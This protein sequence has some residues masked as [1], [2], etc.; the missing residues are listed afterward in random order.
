M[1]P[2]DCTDL[3]FR[4]AR[5]Y[6]LESRPRRHSDGVRGAS[7]AHCYLC[8][9][10]LQ[11][12]QHS[13]GAASPQGRPGSAAVRRESER[14]REDVARRKQPRALD[15]VK[16]GGQRQQDEDIVNHQLSAGGPSPW[17]ARGD[18][19]SSRPAARGRGDN[20]AR[21][22]DG[23]HAE[24]VVQEASTLAEQGHRGPHGASGRRALVRCS[25]TAISSPGP[26]G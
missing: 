5:P 17:A 20:S 11:R 24:L 22:H 21:P 7:G 25:L 23:R 8:A 19:W 10:N 14:A 6:G 26:D 15:L 9:A 1:F 12:A 16:S 18:R 3:S 13:C 2:A 4:T